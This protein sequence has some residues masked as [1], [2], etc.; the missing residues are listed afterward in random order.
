[1]KKKKRQ[2]YDTTAIAAEDQCR[3][4]N[5][6]NQLI[7]LFALP[8][9]KKAGLRQQPGFFMSTTH[10]NACVVK[11]QERPLPDSSR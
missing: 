8:K 9:I 11:K 10:H 3:V 2:A 7:A 5:E 1:L 4:P 6:A